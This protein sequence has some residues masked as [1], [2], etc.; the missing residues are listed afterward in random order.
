MAKVTVTKSRDTDQENQFV[1]STRDYNESKQFVT[2]YAP[3]EIDYSGFAHTYN[4]STRPDRKPVLRRSGR[5]LRKMSMTLFIALPTKDGIPS[6]ER[7]VDHKL[8]KLETLADS[9]IPL[10]VDY[11]P[12]TKGTWFIT[13]MSYRSIERA[14]ESDEITRAEVTLEFT[15]TTD[16]TEFTLNRQKITERP[17]TYKPKKGETLAEIV[18]RFYGTSNAK[19]VA[20][21]AKV[22]DIKN[23]Q[24]LKPGK[25]IKLP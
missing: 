13:N 3:K 5:S 8:D 15:E 22:N 18:K 24:R 1:I 21:V 4:E 10:I 20:A 19:I 16:K 11:E 23:G 9:D 12:R 2:R 7:S 6:I 25:K 14:E 17:K